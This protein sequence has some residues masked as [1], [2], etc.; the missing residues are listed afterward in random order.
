MRPLVFELRDFNRITLDK[1]QKTVNV[2]TGARWWQLQ[3]L[4]DKEGLSV[5]AMQSI[6]IFSVGGTPLTEIWKVS[7]ACAPAASVAF[8][9]TQ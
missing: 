2:Q 8:S 5:K 9:S 7:V 6:N 4:L 1:E 3:Q